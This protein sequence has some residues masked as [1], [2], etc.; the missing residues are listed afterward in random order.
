MKLSWS[1]LKSTNECKEKENKL[2]PL[3][4]HSFGSSSGSNRESSTSHHPRNQF[5]F[6]HQSQINIHKQTH[7]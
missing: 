6:H 3:E 5:L 4:G 2:L 1:G 7:V